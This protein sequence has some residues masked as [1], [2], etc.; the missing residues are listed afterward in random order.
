M[1]SYLL[2]V[3]VTRISWLCDFTQYLKHC[4]KDLLFSRLM[5]FVDTE[6]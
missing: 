2:A 1:I 6:L 4:F 5:F 3:I